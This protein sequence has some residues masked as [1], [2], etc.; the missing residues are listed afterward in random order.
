MKYFALFG[1]CHSKVVLWPVARSVGPDHALLKPTGKQ[2]CHQELSLCELQGVTMPI[3]PTIPL[4]PSA[5]QTALPP[6]PGP[7]LHA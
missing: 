5:T 7:R 4:V 2:H 3:L 6:P 1:S